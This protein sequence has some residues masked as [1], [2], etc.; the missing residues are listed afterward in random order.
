MDFL[1]RLA[2]FTIVVIGQSTL[3]ISAIAEGRTPSALFS[4]SAEQRN[5]LE[6]NLGRPGQSLRPSRSRLLL[7]MDRCNVNASPEEVMARPPIDPES[8][9]LEQKQCLESKVGHP[10]DGSQHT[11]DEIEQAIQIC[12]VNPPDEPSEEINRVESNVPDSQHSYQGVR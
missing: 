12:G 9:T 4:L 3:S 7:V 6:R 11:R 8:L 5:C 10:G 1:K 2:V